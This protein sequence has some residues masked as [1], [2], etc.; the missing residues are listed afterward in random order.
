V[1]SLPRVIVLSCVGGGAP[2]RLVRTLDQEGVG[3]VTLGFGLSGDR[4]RKLMSAS[5]TRTLGR[6]HAFAVFPFQAILKILSHPWDIIVVTTNPFFM[7]LVMTVLR[8][9]H[10]TPVINLVYDLY[11]DA[12]EASGKS[13][14]RTLVGLMAGTSRRTFA[15]A[16]A[17][18]FIGKRMA[19][20][21]QGRYG[22][23]RRSF[24]IPPP[25]DP[26]EFSSACA[27][28]FTTEIERWRGDRALV[29]YVGNLGLMH[30]WDTIARAIRAWVEADERDLAFLL[31][32]S[33]PG[34]TA[35]RAALEPHLDDHITVR[36]S[37][38]LDDASWAHL[39][40]MSD[41][42]I[43]T[44]TET[45][46]RTSVPSKAY[47]ALAAGNS[48]I[49]IAPDDSDVHELACETKQ[50]VAVQ[51][52]DVSGLIAGLRAMVHDRAATGPIGDRLP[53]A[54]RPGSIANDWNAVFTALQERSC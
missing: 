8:P 25:T 52:G 14:S 51:P 26:E 35:L 16:D 54:A 6:I 41:A 5:W 13:L 18:V 31:A 22:D 38:P 46:K 23:P 36:F 19:E 48:L 30:D 1:S 49:V 2:E 47:S 45:A 12:V 43:V 4:W 32:P 34:G 27:T 15:L 9:V 29:T 39:L 3:N 40:K 33:G 10:R 21:A 11:P 28:P 44:L 42:S 50:S 20:H 53:E 24:V 17:T 7:P 37:A